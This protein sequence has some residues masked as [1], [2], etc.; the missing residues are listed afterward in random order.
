ML[1]LKGTGEM[2]DKSLEELRAE[3]DKMVVKITRQLS[4]ILSEIR[5]INKTLKG[6][7]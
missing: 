5:G 3:N 7:A 1:I 2:N 6:A 4:D